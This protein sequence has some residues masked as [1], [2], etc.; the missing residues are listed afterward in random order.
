MVVAGRIRDQL[1]R[2]QA[3]VATAC[4]NGDIQRARSG[5]FERIGEFAPREAPQCLAEGGGAPVLSGVRADLD[6][7]D[8]RPA[9][10]G[11]ALQGRPSSA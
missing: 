1:L 2:L 3:A 10:P 9:I 8:A 11:P 7:R 6:C 4:A 5:R